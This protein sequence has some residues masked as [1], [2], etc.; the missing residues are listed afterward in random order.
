MVHQSKPSC[1]LR[2]AIS[3]K[4][5]LAEFECR[6]PRSWIPRKD[7][8]HESIRRALEAEGKGRFDSSRG[9]PMAFLLA[10]ARNVIRESARKYSRTPNSTTLNREPEDAA[11]SPLDQLITQEQFDRVISLLE[12]SDPASCDLVYRRFGMPGHVGNNA[13]LTN[14]ERS[15]LR[16]IL[17]ELRRRLDN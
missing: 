13:P 2:M 4:E 7:L 6:L 17:T 11:A 1:T 16:R 12:T 14:T 10:I 9:S 3:D 8:S 15:R 5:F